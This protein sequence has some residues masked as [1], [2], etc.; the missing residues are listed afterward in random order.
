METASF[1]VSIES[2]TS[3]KGYSRKFQ[4]GRSRSGM[5][6]S[7]PPVWI[8]KHPI[9]MTLSSGSLAGCP[10]PAFRLTTN[11]RK[12][13][14]YNRSAGVSNV[15]RYLASRTRDWQRTGLFRGGGGG[16]GVWSM[17][18]PAFASPRNACPQAYSD[19]V[20]N[21]AMLSCSSLTSSGA[22]VFFLSHYMCS[23]GETLAFVTG[24]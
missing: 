17:L 20:M 2:R 10:V 14:K 11:A 21:S 8:S 15:K 9:T 23:T 3:T 24:T 1:Q 7:Q 13:C 5:C 4:P 16:G 22:V 18:F 19:H 12:R 6:A